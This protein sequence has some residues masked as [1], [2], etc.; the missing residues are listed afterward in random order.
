M[1]QAAY[2]NQLL[3]H[4]QKVT[5]DCRDTMHEPD[6]QELTVI[7]RGHKFDNAMGADPDKNRGEITIGFVNDEVPGY[8]QEEKA[9]WFNL[10]NIIALARL[11]KV[12]YDPL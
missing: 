6:E 8:L 4:L 11:A 1:R 3:E 7:V 2:F 9:E 10:A 12:E 5:R